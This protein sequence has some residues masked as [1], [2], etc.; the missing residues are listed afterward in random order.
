MPIIVT[1][2]LANGSAQE[3]DR[4]NHLHGAKLKQAPGFIL[5]V[6]GPAEGGWQIAEVRKA[7]SCTTPGF[8]PRWSRTCHPES[9]AGRHG[10]R[11]CT[12]SSSRISSVGSRKRLGTN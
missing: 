5:H 9:W 1:A 6:D 8:R 7:A 10:F 12:A 3:A 2:T 11:T 4:W